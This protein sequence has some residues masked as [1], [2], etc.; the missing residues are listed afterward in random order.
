MALVRFQTGWVPRA[1]IEEYE[2]RFEL[3]VDLPGVAS[4]DVDITL[5]AGVLTLTGERPAMQSDQRFTSSRRERGTGRFHRSFMLPDSVDAGSIRARSRDGVL[6][7][8]I[9]KQAKLLP[10]KIQVAA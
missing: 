5:E 9:P 2:D 3:L 7:V 10:R 1:D 8:R 4:N 6:E